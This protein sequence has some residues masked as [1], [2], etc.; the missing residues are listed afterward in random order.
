VKPI[1]IDQTSRSRRDREIAI[2]F[3]ATAAI[4][5]VAAVVAARFSWRA[6]IRHLKER[7][8]RAAAARQHGDDGIG[9]DGPLP[10]DIL[11]FYRPARDRDYLIRWLTRSAFYHAALYDGPAADGSAAGYVL[12]AR[13]EEVRR[14]SLAGREHNFVV[15]RATEA[16]PEVA[17][18]ALRWAHSQIGARYDR[19]D[20]LTI[21]LEHLFTRWHI[22]IVPHGRYTCAE[23]VATAYDQVGVR[24]VPGHGLDGIDPGDIA[25][26]LVPKS[27]R[28]AV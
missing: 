1:A 11:L 22:N 27:V 21:L 5:I 13:P 25:E 26:R 12:E 20:Q 19:L 9:H 23:L 14:N 6:G 7:Q 24:L 16:K 2:A 15:A 18:A 17:A 28:T 10:G 4:G 8:D 3:G